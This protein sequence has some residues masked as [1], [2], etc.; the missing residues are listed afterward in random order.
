[1]TSPPRPLARPALSVVVTVVGGGSVLRRML[2]ALVGQVSP[3]TLQI[4]VPYDDSRP[5]IGELG[6]AYPGVE[7][8]SIGAI[9]T[10]RPVQ[11]PAGQHEL[12]DRRRTGGLARATGDLVAILED[13][14]PPRPD[15]SATMARLH[16]SLPHAVIGGAIEC[17]PTVRT[18]DWAFYACDFSRFALPFEAGPR[19]W[20]SDVNVCYKRRAIDLT[21]EVWTP[22]F[23]EPAVH[24][25]LLERGET[26]YLSPEAIVDYHPACGSLRAVLSERL[27]WGQLFGWVRAR[28]LSW[29]TRA[30][31]VAVGPLLPLVLYLRLARLAGRLG[32]G[33]RFA[34][35]TPWILL[36]LVA[37]TA[38]EVRGY[39][40][41]RA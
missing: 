14:A 11:S 41:K 4:L 34:G 20:V 17:A 30:A 1:M 10:V 16:A 38:G 37:W 28:S 21:R 32:R 8:F 40:T 39:I 5:E 9:D 24:W 2:D 31:F 3:P 29:P 22:R 36:L 33:R 26:L 6:V 25:H 18:I 35:A 27:Q 15:W 19:R 12:F 23:H 7:F 13:R